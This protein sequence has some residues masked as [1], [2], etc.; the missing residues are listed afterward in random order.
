M[1]AWTLIV[2]L[3]VAAPAGAQ[4]LRSMVVPA[5]EVVVV[6]PRGQALPRPVAPVRVPPPPPPPVVVP[7]P[8]VVLPAGP[9]L[10]AFLPALLPVAGAVL[11]GA[12]S[13]GSGGGTGAP[14]STR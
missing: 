13:P 9:G 4:P 12:G 7:P 6:A 2:A 14:A 1:M 5:D 11:L 10:G 3:V 8:A